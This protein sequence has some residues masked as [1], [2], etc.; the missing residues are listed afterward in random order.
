MPAHELSAYGSNERRH[1][2][3]R[4]DEAERLPS[5]GHHHAHRAGPVIWPAVAI[6]EVV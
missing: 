4:R 6:D 5:S 1:K 2:Q 3:C